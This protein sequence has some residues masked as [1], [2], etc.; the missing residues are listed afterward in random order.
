MPKAGE[1]EH[2]GVNITRLVEAV[3]RSMDR[4]E[5]FREH[6]LNAVK[7]MTGA[8]YGQQQAT[9]ETDV[10]YNLIE[11][12]NNIYINNLTPKNL[13]AFVTAKRKE[14]LPVGGDL[15]AAM[16]QHIADSRL[17]NA[18]RR[19]VQE[20]MFGL[21]LAKV[22]MNT[23]NQDGDGLETEVSNV[24]GSL[25]RVG[26][27]YTEIIPVDKMVIDTNAA[28]FDEVTFVGDMYRMPLEMVRN[29]PRYRK[30]VVAK[31]GKSVRAQG[32]PSGSEE[33][34]GLSVG[35][36]ESEEFYEFVTLL[37]LYLPYTNQVVVLAR[38]SADSQDFL[39]EP[40]V[41]EDF[42]GPPKGPYYP[43]AYITVPGQM[44]PLSPSMTWFSM[45]KTINDAYRKNRRQVMNQKRVL[46]V[47]SGD[48][49]DAAKIRDASDGD[50]VALSN[51][52]AVV[53]EMGYR[54]ME[55]NSMAFLIET[56]N[57]TDYFL[58]NL[59]TLGGLSPQSDTLGQDQ[60][61]QASASKRLLD[62]QDRVADWTRDVLK[63]HGWYF[64]HDPAI[65]V[66][67]TK[68]VKGAPSIK[69]DKNWV[70]DD[71]RAKDFFNYEIDIHPYSKGFDTPEK[72]VAQIVA[73]F[74]NII[75]PGMPYMAEQGIGV[76]WGG[77]I[78][79]L[80]R[81]SGLD[82]V[83]QIILSGLPVH[84]REVGDTPDK[85][86]STTRRYE[87]VNRPGGTQRGKDQVLAQAFAGQDSQAAETANLSRP[88]S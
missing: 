83:D 56:L 28:T 54:G 5:P 71:D 19:G 17:N 36:R 43:L 45:H 88:N 23:M 65:M 25:N 48:E 55:G 6:R 67:F 7:E 16:N 33:S 37:D 11:L 78:S 27:P 82:E 66:P 60:M 64:F 14:N 26:A 73:L 72:K 87:R 84:D 9:G 61:L 63:A 46:A 44:L 47:Q 70:F 21:V 59:S 2:S 8:E 51:P 20:S 22:S 42:Y 40:L 30:E 49:A 41:V 15:Q 3:R 57:R 85:P 4:L 75:A 29:N 50:V 81:Y 79:V 86:Q 13:Q 74:Q 69:I 18:I 1:I 80:A 77:L 35:G 76:D 34:L 12:A 31:L 24:P 10:P 62:M 52:A 53:N 58:G 32:D 39:R 68:R 38:S